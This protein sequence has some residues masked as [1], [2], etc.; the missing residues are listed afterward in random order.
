MSRVGKHPVVI[1]ANVT[2]NI[3]GNDIEVNGPKGSITKSFR[4]D[5]IINHQGSEIT[6]AP[7]SNSVKSR[8]F[9]G[10]YRKMIANM[11]KGVSEGFSKT[12]DIT[13]VGY[14]AAM[15]SNG[16][17][18]KLTLGYSHEILYIPFDKITI[19]CAK[20]TEINVSGIDTQKVG[21]VAAEIR[22]FKK[23]EPYKGKGIKYSGEKIIR[24]EGK[25]K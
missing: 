12:L 24:K 23:P 20:P 9:W 13:G 6:V 8:A 22:S 4:N 18:L 5:V 10:T 25:K 2:V 17:V 21:Q 11:V 14:K 1:P 3:V 7:S 15:I 16:S 19:S